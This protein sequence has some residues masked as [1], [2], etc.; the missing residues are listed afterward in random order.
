MHRWW[1]KK[2]PAQWLSSAEEE[3][4][5]HSH[6]CTPAMSTNSSQVVV[7]LFPFFNI[8]FIKIYIY[9]LTSRKFVTVIF[10]KFNEY[11]YLLPE[12]F[13][14]DLNVDLGWKWTVGNFENIPKV[15]INGI[16]SYKPIHYNRFWCKIFFLSL[17][18]DMLRWQQNKGTICTTVFSFVHSLQTW[19]ILA[20]VMYIFFTIKR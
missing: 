11:Q 16:L 14:H 13:L 10:Y 7:A 6:L 2:V 4:F 12:D 5:F 17:E 1:W 3:C 19:E 9:I 8:I 18:D 15:Q 20:V